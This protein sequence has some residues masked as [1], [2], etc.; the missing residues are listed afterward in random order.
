MVVEPNSEEERRLLG[1]WIKKAADLIVASSAMGESYLD[2]KVQ[3][4][5]EITQRA[6][7]YV[8]FDHEGVLY[9]MNT[10]IRGTDMDIRLARKALWSDVSGK[11]DLP[12]EV[13][14][15][16]GT[17]EAVAI[18]LAHLHALNIH[19][20]GDNAASSAVYYVS[21]LCLVSVVCELLQPPAKGSVYPRDKSRGV[22]APSRYPFP[23]NPLHATTRRG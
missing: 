18:C 23:L 12:D 11:L 15:A 7:D 8:K 13:L 3:R 6:E 14:V 19:L 2:P 1:Q 10:R 4:D 21:R 22:T 16:F 20:A 5:P 9:G 17:I